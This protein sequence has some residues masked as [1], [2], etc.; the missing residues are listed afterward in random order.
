MTPTP[1][2]ILD[3]TRTLRCPRCVPP[4]PAMLPPAMYREVVHADVVAVVATCWECGL[5]LAAMAT[6]AGAV[7]VEWPRPARVLPRWEP[8]G[9]PGVGMH[10]S[11]PPARLRKGG[12]A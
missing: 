4:T 1:A 11:R 10:I 6:P 5:K 12:A 8:T 9:K 7:A 2:A 3:R